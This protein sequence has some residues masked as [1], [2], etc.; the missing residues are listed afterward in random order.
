[1]SSYVIQTKRV[2]MTNYW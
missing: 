2:L 1:M